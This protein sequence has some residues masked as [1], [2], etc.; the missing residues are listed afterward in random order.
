[1]LNDTT[2][3][4]WRQ[5]EFLRWLRPVVGCGGFLH[6][7]FPAIFDVRRQIG[8]FNDLLVAIEADLEEIAGS[9]ADPRAVQDLQSRLNRTLTT[10]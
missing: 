5:E 8:P 10:F 2:E 3:A 1:M 6:K 7:Y 9:K 4:I